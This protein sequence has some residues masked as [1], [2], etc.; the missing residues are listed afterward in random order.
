MP[1]RRSSASAPAVAQRR[2]GARRLAPGE[3]HAGEGRQR[4]G[5]GSA[6]AAA[7]AG[8]EGAARGAP[9]RRR[10]GRRRAGSAPG[11]RATRLPWRRLPE[12]VEGDDRL[13]LA[14]PPRRLPSRESGEAEVVARRR[15]D[16]P[17]PSDRPRPARLERA[18]GRGVRADLECGVTGASRVHAAL[19]QIAGALEARDGSSRSARLPPTSPPRGAHGARGADA[20]RD[21]GAGS[22]S[23][24]E[25]RRE[26]CSEGVGAPVAPDEE[27][28]DGG[29]RRSV[30]AVRARCRHRCRAPGA[31]STRAAARRARA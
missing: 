4:L 22:R 2:D 19:R 13:L 10:S 30:A 25:R 8:P 28:L 31:S 23:A 16:V 9:R 7:R 6:A 18:L 20:T 5:A 11:T 1:P 15:G 17:G 21:R 26:A 29:R 12:G 27:L 24:R 14:A 3:Q